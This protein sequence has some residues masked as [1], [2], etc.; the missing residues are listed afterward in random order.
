M[1]WPL[2]V[3][4]CHHTGACDWGWVIV[5]WGCCSADVCYSNEGLDLLVPTLLELC[6]VAPRVIIWFAQV[7]RSV[8]A[9][10]SSEVALSA[11]CVRQA[12]IFPSVWES[13]AAMTMALEHLR[14]ELGLR[15]AFCRTRS[16]CQVARAS[17]T[18]SSKACSRQP[19][20]A[21]TVIRQSS[22]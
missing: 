8:V 10:G 20:S 16:V 2:A 13:A 4:A 1:A 18:A 7:R 21:C 6:A 12:R 15:G 22:C 19:A 9:A 11:G 5:C 3:S 14:V 17:R